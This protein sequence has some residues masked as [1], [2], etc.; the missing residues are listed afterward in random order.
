MARKAPPRVQDAVHR[1][2]RRVTFFAL[3]LLAIEFLDEFVF[4][5]REAAWP[6]VRDD[7]GLTYAQV[8]VLLG[9]PNVI[10]N[11]VEP[12]LGVL[13]GLWKL[14]EIVLGGGIVFAAALLLTA[15]SRSFAPLLLSFIFFYPASG[16]FVSLSQATLMDL[17]PERHEQGMAR[18]TFAGSLGVVA[19][20]L[21]LGGATALALGWRGLFAIF[22]G[23]T[24]VLLALVWRFP[25]NTRSS[26]LNGQRE[27]GDPSPPDVPPTLSTG[28]RAA[29]RALGRGEVLRWLILLEFSDLMLDVLLGFL[30]L[31]MVDVARLTQ[32]QAEAAVLVWTGVGLLGD[33][34]L[35]PL[36]E[37]VRGLSYLRVSVIVELILFP[38]FLLAP[39]IWAKFILLGLLGL[40]NSGWY[41]ILQ[42]G[43]YSAMPG[44]SGTA[45]AVKNVSGLAGGLIPLML[46][47][48]AQRFGLSAAMWLLLLGPIV[49]LVGL[50]R[51]VSQS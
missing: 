32:T 49:L 7:L 26:D 28:L 46:G 24:V 33:F 11:A 36:L 48:V 4:G 41:A 12:F 9:V 18:W 51:R 3:V 8:G 17:E 29:L 6:L 15:L 31:Y 34:L 5:A 43:L 40:F 47:L 16:A 30:A 21:A 14:R 39:V 37:R 2:A 45:L 22:A 42:A 10:G 44:Q 25:F 1:T 19:G 27:D 20:P 50:P 38:A 13:G 35:I 23:L